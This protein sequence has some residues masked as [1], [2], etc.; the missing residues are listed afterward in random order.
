[1][2]HIDPGAT[3]VDDAMV[4]Y[5]NVLAEGVLTSGAV[6]DGGY[7]ENLLGPQTFDFWEPSFI[8]GSGGATCVLA[9]PMTADCAAIIGHN[10]ASVGAQVS[11]QHRPVGGAWTDPATARITPE[12]NE[13]ILFLFP[14]RIAEAYRVWITIPAGETAPVRPV[15]SI[16]MI[17]QRLLIPGGVRAG[18]TPVNLAPNIE[19]TPH[20]S[21]GGQFLG[22]THN[23]MGAS[24]HIPLAMQERGW[25]ENEARPFIEHYN[26][27][28]PFVWASCPQ[29]MPD[30]FAYGW[31]DGDVLSAEYGQGALYGDM[32]MDVSAYIG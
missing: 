7:V 1:M 28:L 2:I 30:D 17:G 10:L 26:K 8:T 9:E 3:A 14:E 23:I 19:T 21:R 11:I 25:I 12:T 18:Y 22:V 15:I 4:L 20:M 31:R 5:R 32:S 29:L 27:G 13:D 16:A 24:T 6:A